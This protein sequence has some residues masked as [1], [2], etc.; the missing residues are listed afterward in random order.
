MILN[1]QHIYAMN[2]S[3]NQSFDPTAFF[4]QI[5]EE[6]SKTLKNLFKNKI[7]GN[8]LIKT[9]REVINKIGPELLNFYQI[10]FDRTRIMTGND[11]TIEYDICRIIVGIHRHHSI[12]LTEQKIRDNQKSSIYL[13]TI[14]NEVIEKIQFRKYGNFFFRKNQIFSGDEFL[15]FPVPYELFVLC[16]RSIDLMTNQPNTRFDYYLGIIKNALASLTLMENNLLNNAYPLCRGMIEQYVKILILKKHPTSYKDYDRF[17]S[18]EINQSC[19]SQKYPEE[20]IKEFNQRTLMSS[21]SKVDYLHYGWL[22]SISDY[23]TQKNN[24]YS[25]YGILEY[26]SANVIN[27]WEYAKINQLEILYKM[28][29]GYTHGSVLQVRY[30]LLQYFEISIMIKHVIEGIFYDINRVLDRTINSEDEKLLNILNRDFK[31]LNTQYNN[32]TAEKIE[33]Y[34]NTYHTH[35]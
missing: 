30:P 33:L 22:D 27:D 11:E 18:Y 6:N 3:F 26:I 14:V 1:K 34:Y 21:N 19:C 32:R 15:Y 7:N 23:N 24:R 20:F 9:E 5:F 12:F 35:N 28:C 17:C 25:I 31:L 8:F 4:I 2:N 10:N 16:M 29:H 13:A